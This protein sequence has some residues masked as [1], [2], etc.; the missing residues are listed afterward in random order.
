MQEQFNLI[1]IKRKTI[2]CFAVIL[3]AMIGVTPALADYLGPHRTIT[4]T[5]SICKVILYKCQYVAAKGDYR[6]KAVNNWSCSNEDKPWQDYSSSSPAC[7]EGN[8]NHQYWERE[9]VPQTVTN[10]YPPATIYNTLENCTL[11]NGW[12]ATAPQIT[13]NG[14]E[15][16]AGYSIVAIE[17]SLNGQTFACMNSYCSV[18]L[19]QGNNSLAYWALSSF[20]D[21][22]TMGTLTVYVDSQPPNIAGAF[23]GTLGSNGWY[24]SSVSFNGSASDTTSGL[25]SFACTSDG[26]ALGSCN[27]INI[28]GEGSHTLILTAR[29]NAGLIS[30]LTQNASIDT[31]N[32]TLNASISGKLGSNNWYTTATLNASASDPLPG[33]GLAVFEYN[34]DSNGWMTFPSSGTL[35]LS[36][37]KHSVDI[38]VVD[39]AGHT[40]STSKSFWLDTSAPKISVYSDGTSGADGW[41][42]TTLTVTASANDDTS[43]MNTFEYSLDNSSWTA[44]VTPLTLSN[45]T[46]SLSFWAQDE[47]GLVTQV[48]RTYRVDTRVPQIAGGLS[49][50]LGM[51]GWY[52]SDVTL[53]ASASDPLP[54]SGLDVFT[55]TLS[56]STE[57]PY[58]NP[59]TLSDGQHTVQLNARDKAGLSY[60]IE[61]SLRVDTIPPSLKIKTTLPSWIKDEITLNGT[62]SD[63]G[64][65]L[66]KVEISI[67]SEQT[68]QAVT[69]TDTWSYAWNTSDI[70]NGTHQVN[71]RT[72]NLAG[73]T[74]QQ[75]FNI[76]VD[77]RAPEISL[78]DSWFQWDTV[79][80]NILDN[81]SGL[82]EARVEITDPKGR[83]PK[84]VIQLN[85]QQFPLGF[86]WDRRFGDNT[87]AGAGTYDVK[88][89]ALDSLGN[90]ADKNASIHILLDILPAGPTTTPQPTSAPA[91][92][93]PVNTVTAILSP[94]TTD[95]TITATSSPEAT[96]P[97]IT[98]TSSP[99]ATQ[100]VAVSVFG[101]IDPPAQ[102]TPTSSYLPTP[103]PSPTQVGVLDLLQ[104]IFVPIPNEES[105]T[106]I[107]SL[108][109]ATQS[110][111]PAGTDNNGILWG[112]AAAA[113]IGSAMA[114]VQEEK[115]K[116]EEEKAR[117]AAL[118]AQEEERREKKQE[119]KL[120]K[121]EA[122]RAQE[123]AWQ[124]AGEEARRD[125][126][127]NAYI[128]QNDIKIARLEAEEETRRIASQ[129]ESKK[130]AEE[131]KKAEELNER[132]KAYY[133]APRQGEKEAAS[134]Q[135]MN[136][137]EKTKSLVSENIIQPVDTYLYQPFVKP[138]I[139]IRKEMDANAASWLNENFYQP[140]IKPAVEKT[141]QFI[142]SESTWINEKV[143]QPVLKPAIERT[144]EFVSNETTWINEK[145]Y[146]PHIQPAV[147]RTKEFVV[148][149]STWINEKIYQPYIQPVVTVINEKVYQ[150]YIQPIVEP[151]VERSKEF[152][153]SEFAW[154][155]EN[156]YEPILEPVVSDINQYI[157]QP[158]VRKVSPWWDQYGEWVHG[159]LDAAGVFP[160]L[161]ETAD[162]I[163]A[164]IY[165][166]EGRYLEAGISAISMLPILGDLGKA[167]KWTLE[168][169]Q[170][171]I[172]K[173]VK[174]IAGDLI[175]K[176][177]KESLEEIA[178]KGLK[179]VGTE[180]IENTW[181]HEALN[182]FGCIPGAS[183]MTTKID[184][185]IH[186]A[187][188]H[189]LDATIS[190]MSMV[191]VVGSL[192]T[193]GK[194]V[195]E[196]SFERLV[197][198]ATKELEEKILKETLE[199]AAEKV[200]KDASEELIEK[201]ATETLEEVAEK[202]VKEV[203]EETVEKIAKEGSEKLIAESIKETGEELVEKATK[204]TFEEG[205]EK[206][207]K[208]MSEEVTEKTTKEVF[209]EAVEKAVNKVQKE[210]KEDA[211]IEKVT[212]EDTDRD[213]TIVHKD[214]IV[215]ETIEVSPKQVA[216]E[217]IEESSKQ[218]DEK[219]INSL[220]EQHGEEM[221]SDFLLSCEKYDINP[222]DLITRPLAE[223]QSLNGWVL[224]IENPANPINKPLADLNLTD[225]ELD[226]I[227]MQ[228][229][230]NPDSQIVVL[231]YGN[232]CDKPYYKLG[233][234]IKGSYLSL[235]DEAWA[236]F[237]EA[238]ANFWTDINGPFLENAIE[239]RKILLFNVQSDVIEDP[240]NIR[241][242]SLPEL[243]LIEM[244]KNNYIHVPIGEYS[245]YIPIESQ[246]TFEQ[247]LPANLLGIGE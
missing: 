9:D 17:G 79:T 231:G 184:S 116:R 175:Q 157:Y 153:T 238:Q 158:L 149:E 203:S 216:E 156:I 201:A 93:T 85:P 7:N 75:T 36:D 163:N 220:R 227:R 2:F 109:E 48:D 61:Q 246:D 127:E 83:W 65:G 102:A 218:V 212:N 124:Q 148:N 121:M 66:S 162:G 166:V 59:L 52:I 49:G 95:L 51:N 76:G 186:L 55:Y 181:V 126:I 70:P 213:T 228:S 123:Q 241:R 50:V 41:S 15:P 114:Y 176:A 4:E 44:Y 54:G 245:A 225:A 73:L 183:P 43:G 57:T 11:Q 237:S 223:G 33:S 188:G 120:E 244:E 155:N 128:I 16:V 194:G 234:E 42:T 72:I 40:V 71:L 104:S 173:A 131:K 101:K 103:R 84:R 100:S 86:K 32:P 6:Y 136:W 115:R 160:G 247:Y 196:N 168:A 106:E 159:A 133:S 199:E 195:I 97:I 242:F 45:G 28:N 235:S 222:Q 243:R 165:L 130:Q 214:S 240:A 90:M 5:S 179:E 69:G 110:P 94:T 143:Y 187:G 169:G 207:L 174:G 170:E 12:C 77:N 58:T 89:T 118:E 198:E 211:F 56:G 31:Q 132:L 60:S 108:D 22:S 197:K 46:H 177:A 78:P 230:K 129:I 37:G 221:V 232:G 171:V 140:I 193:V 39:Q 191:P 87:I 202:T 226:N 3:I 139:E 134:T 147:D 152:I 219:F 215:E 13:L 161:G 8:V 14:T 154:I 189:Y 88:V 236:P 210:L 145:I 18:P 82:S 64:S 99:K 239:D 178:E 112:T 19:P 146:Q 182:L 172:D 53:S 117:Q 20:G 38:H 209:E 26:V 206:A 24:L 192:V 80:L 119:R 91:T 81:H 224:D 47:A 138:A 180:L 137:W 190:A 229:T 74:A 205:T 63:N 164:L 204:V 111:Q 142:A 30:T 144:K 98:A 200:V 122:I 105:I 96:E 141:K 35:N 125:K 150:P 217:R 29:D 167:G 10:T 233:D 21:S 23:A 113:A 92:S 25:A 135:P 68:W 208:E 107:G 67:D 151:I 185:L 27:N 34:F 1:R 62:A